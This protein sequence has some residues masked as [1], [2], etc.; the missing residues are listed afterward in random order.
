MNN[1]I[2]I[3][4][5][6]LSVF[7]VLFSFTP[8]FYELFHVKDLPKER[9]F[10]LEHNY[11][12]DY[13]FYLSRIREGG[14]G[15]W[16]ISEKYYNLPHAGSFFQIVYLYLGKIGS[17]LN[18]SSPAVYHLSRLLFGF[19]LL[20][21]IG[22]YLLRFFPNWWAVVGYLLIVTS[23][24]YPILVKMGTGWRF[25]TH[26]GW[27]SAIDSLQRITFIPHVLIGQIFLILFIWQFGDN[28][29]L[30]YFPRMILIWGIIGFI[31]G[32]IFPPTLIVIYTV[33]GVLS[34]IEFLQSKSSPPA[35]AFGNSR[36][37]AG[38][39]L[40][41]W[42]PRIVFILLSF[43]SLAY[44]QLMFKVAPWSALAL[45]DVQHRI[46][47]SYREYALALGPVLPLGVA[48]LFLAL[49]NK[50]KKF[51]ATAA[52]ITSVAL[53]FLIFE[54]VPQQSPSRFTEAMLYVPL[55]IF[56]TY[57][58]KTI[59]D[60]C[61]NLKFPLAKL[62]KIGSGVVITVI[63]LIGMGVMS[64]MVLWLNDQSY[65]KRVGAWQVPIGAQIAYP[66][67]DFMDGVFYLRDHTPKNT[68]VLGYV[69]SGNFIPAYAGNYVYIGHA[70]TPDEDGK[71]KTAALF[72][73]GKMSQNEGR[74][75][76]KKE[77]VSYIY[78]GPQEKELG[79]VED[80]AG[81][82]PFLTSIYF[83]P[84]VVIYKT[85]LF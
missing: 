66:L 77:R 55:G 33:F 51:M 64:S 13:N 4:I 79:K 17:L 23:G 71:E 40:K 49:F 28:K 34:I 35:I 47:L 20:T 29:L 22:V 61:Q 7:F 62:V 8:S 3:A 63:V 85:E 16:L 52:W 37:R 42:I 76:L 68:V 26:M 74:E 36:W 75:F 45:F 80:L 27:W 78:F 32:I 84:K 48:G 58:F 25:A 2:K 30:K 44:L 5:F 72:F 19:T 46:I 12:F 10:V 18:L 38:R 43:P 69:T 39:L 81:I 83:N 15:R 50:E 21:L 9:F 41:R 82:Y 56:A 73:S 59:W 70:N 31:A 11:M 54:K 67:A 53:L 24:S 6:L 60:W 65:G 57:L 1:K 14:E